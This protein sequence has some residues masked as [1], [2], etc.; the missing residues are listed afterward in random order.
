MHRNWLNLALIVGT[1]FLLAGTALYNV[2]LIIQSRSEIPGLADSPLPST[3]ARHHII[4]ILPETAD[5]FMTDLAHSIQEALLAKNSAYQVFRYA[6]GKER[7]SYIQEADRQFTLAL[8]VK[9]DGIIIFFLSEEPIPSFLEKARKAGLPCVP[10]SLDN[11]RSDAIPA[12]S[13][14]SYLHGKAAAKE[15]VSVLGRAARIGVIM[16]YNGTESLKIDSFL[17]GIRTALM[18]QGAGTVTSVIIE[19]DSVLGGEEAGLKLLEQYPET[20]VLI[21]AS[22]QTS[23]SAAQLIVDK[24]LAGRVLLIGADETPEIT[25]L[26][27]KGIFQA[28]IVRDA[29]TIGISA[30]GKLYEQIAGSTAIE[31]VSVK[32]VI[33]RHGKETQ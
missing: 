9:A 16:P 26:L 30:V 17:L 15:A 5:P 10:I 8:N 4:V 25:R 20:N 11:P 22:A 14:D 6:S 28:I 13:S 3:E 18:E 29:A 33:K 32:P 23:L 19:E 21:C 7:G 31:P 24:G 27:E 1:A 12:V 2:A